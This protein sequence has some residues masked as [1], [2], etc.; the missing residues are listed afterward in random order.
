MLRAV[1]DVQV[2]D[3]QRLLLLAVLVATALMASVVWAIPS[4]RQRLGMVALTLALLMAY[5]YGVTALGN[6]VLDRTRGSTYATTV[7]GKHVTSGRNR[8]PTMQLGP[9]GP[10]ATQEEATVPWDVYRSTNVGEKVCVALH[11]G[12]FG[13]PWYRIARCQPTS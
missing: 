12:A 4:A 2:L 13:V 10:R 6:A 5:G 1:Q 7:Y 3:W 8:T 11:P 9:W